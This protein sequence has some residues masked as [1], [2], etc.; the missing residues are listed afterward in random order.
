MASWGAILA[1][2][3]FRYHGAE[4]TLTL[5]PAMAQN[6]LSSFWSTT[7]GWGTFSL[8]ASTAAKALT[9]KVAHGKL[10]CRSVSLVGWARAEG[11]S[12]ARVSDRTSAHELRYRQNE[13][14]FV[15]PEELVL[16][17]GEE[18]ALKVT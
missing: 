10:A 7:E 17:E 18:F 6:E 1:L 4:R 3:G 8:S 9:L 13:A 5:A 14:I 2:S 12:T 15:F 16:K 11:R